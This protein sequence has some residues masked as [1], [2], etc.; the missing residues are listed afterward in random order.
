ML[1]YFF[2]VGSIVKG[3]CGCCDECAKVRGETCGGTFHVFGRC[4]I[5]LTCKKVRN[6]NYG[7]C[8]ESS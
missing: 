4:D 1:S 6:Q 8:G 7:Y 5:G 2:M 3:T